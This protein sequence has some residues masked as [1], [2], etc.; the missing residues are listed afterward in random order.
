[1]QA[2]DEGSGDEGRE[3]E[4]IGWGV[5]MDRRISKGSGVKSEM[6]VGGAEVRRW[7]AELVVSMARNTNRLKWYSSQAWMHAECK[8][9]SQMR[10]LLVNE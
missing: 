8:I 3:C 10:R 6:G 4:W 9:G 2:E 7:G 1:M 5:R